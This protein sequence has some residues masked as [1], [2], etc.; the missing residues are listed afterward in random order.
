MYWLLA[1]RQW[2]DPL[3]RSIIVVYT[4][5]IVGLP[6]AGYVFAYIDWRASYR[7]LRRALVLVVKYPTLLPDWIRRERPRCLEV[8]DLHIPFTT[9]ELLAIYRE[10]VKQAHPDRGGDRQKFLEL[11]R[12]FEQAQALAED[13]GE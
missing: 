12:Y 8:F 10:K 6:L 13:Y 9:A 3:D 5:V 7:R 2:P 1:V 4:A 11:Q